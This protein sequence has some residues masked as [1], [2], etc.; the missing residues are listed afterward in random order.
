MEMNMTMRF[1]VKL[2]LLL[3]LI[4][5]P[6]P[7]TGEEKISAPEIVF[8]PTKDLNRAPGFSEE[9]IGRAHV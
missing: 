8:I 3:I 4:L 1:S 2:L 5:T 6:V 9:E 7:G